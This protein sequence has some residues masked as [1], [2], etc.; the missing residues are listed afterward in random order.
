MPKLGNSVESS[1]IVNWRKRLGDVVK[2]GEALLEVETDKATVEVESQANGTLLAIFF[3]AGAD[4]AVMTPIAAIGQPGEDYSALLPGGVGTPQSEASHW[5]EVSATPSA[6][7]NGAADVRTPFMASISPTS[8]IL[9]PFIASSS[10]TPDTPPADIRVSP[11]ARSLATRKG[12]ALAGI[13]GT[14]PGGRI[15]ERD[16]QA[17]LARQLKLTPVAERMVAQGGFAIPEGVDPGKK[18]T[19]RD[20]VPSVVGAQYIAPL[21]PITSPQTMEATV[22]PM[23]GIRRTIAT[24]MLASLQTTAQLTL[25]AYADARALKALRERL[26]TSD[27]ALGLRGVTINDLVLYATAKA[28]ARFPDLNAHLKDDAIHQYPAVHLGF[29]VD[30]PRGLIVPVIKNAQVRTLRD[31][32]AEAARLA[33]A[34]QDGSIKP[35]DLDGGTFTVSNLGGLGIDT[36]TPVLNPPQVAILGVGGIALRP[37]EVDDDVKFIPHIPLSLTIDHRAVDGAPGARF[38]QALG[39]NLANVD[40]LLGT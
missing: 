3:E 28:L 33:K 8:D 34:C 15:I 10:P 1:I 12:V 27:E 18:I 24:R 31:L 7:T 2:E 14:G 22:I 21:Q 32:S 37:V 40:V 19:T 35:D 23:K 36:F 38:L 29:A 20:L 6:T 4:V 17:F 9:P 30:T 26:K 11:R 16:I 5:D 25:N 13:S 39:R